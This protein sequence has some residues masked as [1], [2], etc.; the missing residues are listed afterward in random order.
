VRN[1]SA[2]TASAFNQRRFKFFSRDTDYVV[3]M[4]VLIADDDGLVRAAL[5][6]LLFRYFRCTVLDAENGTEALRILGRSRVSMAI[7]DIEMPT[8]SGVELLRAIRSSSEHATLP[9]GVIS[10]MNDEATVREVIALG[11]SDYFIK[12]LKTEKV[13]ARLTRLVELATKSEPVLSAVATRHVHDE[14]T[15]TPSE[16]TPFDDLLQMYPALRQDLIS[17]T[18]QALGMMAEC[19]VV[20]PDEPVSDPDTSSLEALVRLEIEDRPFTVDVAFGCSEEAATVVASRMRAMHPT[21]VSRD[22]TQASLTEL[23]NVIAGRLQKGLEDR[24][25]QSR[26][27]ASA[28]EG[29]AGERRNDLVLGFG[30]AEH[31]IAFTVCVRARKAA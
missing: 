17:A 9:V 29:G 7:I 30:S 22:D 20:P 25:C 14:E 28:A 8:M 19:E 10:G 21:E 18:E 11:V 13:V 15:T 16:G 6:R 27:A 31:E 26:L 3:P 24:G 23:A 1:Q 2:L 4:T 12:P 5:K